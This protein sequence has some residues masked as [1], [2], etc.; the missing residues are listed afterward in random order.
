MTEQVIKRQGVELLLSCLD[1]TLIAKAKRGAPQPSHRFSVGVRN[2]LSRDHLKKN[3]GARSSIAVEGYS[4]LL[5]DSAECSV[6]N[7]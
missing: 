3:K 4:D 7:P 1:Q 2:N 5:A 6:E